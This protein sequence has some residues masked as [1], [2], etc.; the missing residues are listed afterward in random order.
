ML[1]GWS[2]EDRAMLL[3]QSIQLTWKLNLL[4]TCQLGTRS[5]EAFFYQQIILSWFGRFI[6]LG[7]E[8]EYT[9]YPPMIFCAVLAETSARD[10]HLQY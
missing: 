9:P 1:E 2:E 8:R 5:A 10:I 4:P 6:E 3:I 7:R